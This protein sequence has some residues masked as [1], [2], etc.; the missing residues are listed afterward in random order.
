MWQ[1]L[2][3]TETSMLKWYIVQPYLWRY[4]HLLSKSRKKFP[5]LFSISRVR[6]LIRF[7]IPTCQTPKRQGE[8][9]KWRKTTFCMTIFARGTLNANQG[10]YTILFAFKYKNTFRLTQFASRPVTPVLSTATSGH[11]HVSV[12]GNI[13]SGQCRNQGRPKCC[14]IPLLNTHP[15]SCRW[16][17]TSCWECSQTAARMGGSYCRIMSPSSSQRVSIVQNWHSEV[18]LPLSSGL[19]HCKNHMFPEKSALSSLFIRSELSAGVSAP[20]ASHWA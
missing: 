4:I 17:D 16:K 20:T 9:E 2:M 11:T 1:Q 7:P 13:C 15:S 14:S 19:N 6:T 18:P 5:V 10:V 12:T 3:H 8:K